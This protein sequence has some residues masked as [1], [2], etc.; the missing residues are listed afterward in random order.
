MREVTNLQE[1]VIELLENDSK[2]ILTL[3]NKQIKCPSKPQYPFYEDLLDTQVFGFS[4]VIDFL[5]RLGLIDQ[6]EG[7]GMIN[8]LEIRLNKCIEK[9]PSLKSHI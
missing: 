2:R 5:V 4:Q 8:N 7:R 3:L 9:I 1:S 6:T